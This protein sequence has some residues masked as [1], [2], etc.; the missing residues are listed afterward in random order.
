VGAIASGQ[1]Q[2]RAQQEAQVEDQAK[3]QAASKDLAR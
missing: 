1:R 2:R 3:Q